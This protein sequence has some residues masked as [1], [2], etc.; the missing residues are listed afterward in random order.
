M[1]L[2]FSEL[3]NDRIINDNLFNPWFDMIAAYAFSTFMLGLF[4]L[5]INR[6]INDSEV[7][8]VLAYGLIVNGGVMLMFGRDPF[9]HPF[10]VLVFF[11]SLF[12][13]VAAFVA[14]LT[15]MA[16]QRLPGWG[17]AETYVHDPDDHTVRWYL[18]WIITVGLLVLF[19]LTA[20]APFMILDRVLGTSLSWVLAVLFVCMVSVMGYGLL[21]MNYVRE[22]ALLGETAPPKELDDIFVFS[23]QASAMERMTLPIVAVAF[24]GVGVYF[25]LHGF[26]MGTS[27]ST[28]AIFLLILGASILMT[29]YS[30][31]KRA[32]TF[33]DSA[34]RRRSI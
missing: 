13:C 27:D 7:Y 33:V 9:P 3:F 20:S 11:V 30:R 26:D 6:R 31:S 12:F 18:P 29:E 24:W 10:F 34:P 23:G 5:W 8:N 16:V 32:A 25:A 1:L 22:T 19:W 21:P 14:I 15:V 17:V 28:G 4:C 2:G